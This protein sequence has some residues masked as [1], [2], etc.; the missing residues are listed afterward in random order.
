[1]S[2]ALSQAMMLEVL[3]QAARTNTRE[4]F[5]QL[6][7]GPLKALLGYE[8]MMYGTG[9]LTDDGCY[10]HKLHNYGYPLDYF[11]ELE[12]ADG[13]VD[14]PLMKQWRDTMKPVYFQSGRDDANFSASWIEV[15]NRYDLRNTLGNAMY[16]RHGKVASFF[17]FARLQ[18]EVGPEHAHIL[19]LITPNLCAAIARVLESSKGEQFRFAGA[20]QKVFSAKQMDVLGWLYHGKTN[21]EIAQI[22]DMNEETVKYHVEQ[23]MKKLKVSSRTQV[24]A[25]AVEYGLISPNRR[26]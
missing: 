15:F 3:A 10:T 12:Q 18:G 1:M 19:E 8:Y 21:S 22:L 25:K 14:S 6:V 26:S 7:L 17:I 11:F 5:D 20:V 24:V 13:T 23:L 9:F 2:S 16:D 4:D